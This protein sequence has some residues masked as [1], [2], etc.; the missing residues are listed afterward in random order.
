VQ[1]AEQLEAERATYKGKARELKARLVATDADARQ[2]LA[3][4][5][6][7]IQARVHEYERA[8][9][10]AN[11]LDRSL[12]LATSEQVQLSCFRLV[13]HC[14]ALWN[15]SHRSHVDVRQRFNGGSRSGSPL[16]HRRHL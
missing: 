10:H 11:E 15:P 3:T 13:H 16:V 5:Q 7:Q 8:C 6:E 12:A 2:K 1:R 4:M 14:M 9:A